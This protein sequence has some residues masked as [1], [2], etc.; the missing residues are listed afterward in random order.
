MIIFII[1]EKFKKYIS[2]FFSQ[3][4]KNYMYYS[5]CIVLIIINCKMSKILYKSCAK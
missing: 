4:F 3:L 1:Q 2:Y 5:R